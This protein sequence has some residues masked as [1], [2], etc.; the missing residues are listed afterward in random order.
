MT[1]LV[2][3]EWTSPGRDGRGPRRSC[4]SDGR[5]TGSAATAP[6]RPTGHSSDPP[7]LTEHDRHKASGGDGFL[8]R[9]TIRQRLHLPVSP[10]VRPGRPVGKR[11]LSEIPCPTA[12]H[13]SKQPRNV[14]QGRRASVRRSTRSSGEQQGVTVPLSPAL[15][16]RISIVRPDQRL[17]GPQMIAASQADVSWRAP[18]PY[19]GR[20]QLND[21]PLLPGCLLMSLGRSSQTATHGR[22]FR[23]WAVG[24]TPLSSRF[25]APRLLWISEPEIPAAID[26]GMLHLE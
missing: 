11:S 4:L 13:D 2:R 19:Q 6:A 14:L 22:A 8:S 24:S 10:T 16:G 26:L 21:T 20:P 5:P 17:S 1:L 23:R 18:G 7:C 15:R 12:A 25:G 9:K 3:A